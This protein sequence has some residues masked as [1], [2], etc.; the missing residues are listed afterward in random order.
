MKDFC[1]LVFILFIALQIACGDGSVKINKDAG[2]A[3]TLPLGN[4][5]DTAAQQ[6]YKDYYTT[7]LYPIMSLP[8]QS[9]GGC[10]VSGCH[11]INDAF[12]SDQTF[13]QV[14]PSGSDNSWN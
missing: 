3:S 14:D 2:T 9:Q 11:L 12:S 7:N 4:L 13:F 6:K 1:F 5:I 8:D 10:A